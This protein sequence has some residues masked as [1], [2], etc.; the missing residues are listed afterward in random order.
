M[1]DQEIQG[2]V[3]VRVRVMVKV[4]VRVKMVAGVGAAGVVVSEQRLMTL[5]S[6]CGEILGP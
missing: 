1:K 5:P 2:V 6:Q 3:K 4:K